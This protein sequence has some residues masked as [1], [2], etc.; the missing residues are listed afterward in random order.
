VPAWAWKLVCS[1]P[2]RRWRQLCNSDRVMT[3][4]SSHNLRNP[5]RASTNNFFASLSV[6]EFMRHGYKWSP[7]HRSN[8]I[9]SRLFNAFFVITLVRQ[10]TIKL[11]ETSYPNT[12]AI[13]VSLRPRSPWLSK[14]SVLQY[15]CMRYNFNNALVPLLG[16][17]SPF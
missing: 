6:Q 3:E 2:N 7:D 13:C 11:T 16:A 12:W 4:A 1:I 17:Q 9:G 14:T 10:L 5:G 15:R 8:P